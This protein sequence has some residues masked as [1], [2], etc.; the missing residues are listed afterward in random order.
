MVP[1]PY[2]SQDCLPVDKCLSC[3]KIWFDADELEILQVLIEERLA[4][5]R[6][7]PR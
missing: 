5:R 3:Q 6:G 7:V 1:R 2:S 4:K